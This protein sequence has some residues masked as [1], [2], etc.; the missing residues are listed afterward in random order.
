MSIEFSGVNSGGRGEYDVYILSVH[1]YIMNDTI[2]TFNVQIKFEE[3]KSR[4]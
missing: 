1:I 2:I 4:G 3:R